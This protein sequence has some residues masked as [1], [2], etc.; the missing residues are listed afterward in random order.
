MPDAHVLIVEDDASLLRGLADNF[1]GAGYQVSSATDGEQ[2]L[3]QAFDLQPDLIVLDLML[4][5]VNGYEICR[6][7]R[8]AD[9]QVPIIILSAKGEEPDVILGL[10]IGANDYVTKPFSIKEL[11]ARANAA[12]RT[13]QQQ[14]LVE[15]AQQLEDR[16]EKLSERLE[17]IGEQAA[18][19]GVEQ[20]R[21]SA[22]EARQQMQE[23]QDQAERLR[24][25]RDTFGI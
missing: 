2:G 17:E 18:A 19:E 6:T 5:I 3:A 25:R 20:A 9:Q 14:D 10:N 4:P 1:R 13:E 11:L 23:A 16:M 7:L 12:L 21:E 22:S 15:Q 8:E 24:E